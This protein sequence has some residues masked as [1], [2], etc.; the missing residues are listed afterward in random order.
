MSKHSSRKCSLAIET[1]IDEIAAAPNNPL[2]AFL[3]YNND[4]PSVVMNDVSDPISPSIPSVSTH[5]DK[6][7]TTLGITKSYVLS[8]PTMIPKSSSLPNLQD[9]NNSNNNN[10]ITTM[11]GNRRISI[12]DLNTFN[13]EV[14]QSRH[15]SLM[16]LH[17]STSDI[18]KTTPRN[19]HQH[20]KSPHYIPNDIDH[21]HNHQQQQQ[22]QR[23]DEQQQQQQREGDDVLLPINFNEQFSNFH[24]RNHK[25]RNTV[26]LKFEE[27]KI[28]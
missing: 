3:V 8:P 10:T 11:I 1:P 14:Y 5:N 24:F 4:N 26:A 15:P 19:F 21:H 2:N 22:Q 13:G 9:V 12:C 7:E 20:L 17:L 6:I 28:L 27:P 16:Y 25:R 23:D 18:T